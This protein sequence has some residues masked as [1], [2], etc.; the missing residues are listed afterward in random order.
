MELVTISSWC[1][2]H[3]W[4]CSWTW[5]DSH[6]RWEVLSGAIKRSNGKSLTNG[7]LIVYKWWVF[8]PAMFDYRRVVKSHVTVPWR[9]SRSN[10]LKPHVSWGWSWIESN[11]DG[12]L[13]S[14]Y[15]WMC[16]D[17]TD[18]TPYGVTLATGCFL[19][20][21]LKV[22]SPVSPLFSS[23]EPYMGCFFNHVLP[24]GKLT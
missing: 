3:D 4:S 14:Q 23:F 1:Q 10:M 21:F 22:I 15:F 18:H 12:H 17:H 16:D 2:R 24:S 8:Q 19:V 20:D 5:C 6:P 11:R 7:D 9:F 13:Y